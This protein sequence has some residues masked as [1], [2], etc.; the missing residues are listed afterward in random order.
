[1]T[2]KQPAWMP[3]NVDIRYRPWREF[4]AA[5]NDAGA[6]VAEGHASLFN[7]L[8]VDL[9]GFREQVAPGA[10]AETIERDDIVALFNHDSNIPLGRT[11]A[12]TLRL[13]E[14]ERGLFSSIDI[15]VSQPAIREAIVRGDV[16]SQSIAFM[17][18]G[19]EDEVWEVIDGTPI[20]TILRAR[21][22]D[23]SPVVFPAQ[24][25]TD[26]AKRSLER[27]VAAGRLNPRYD[28]L[29]YQ[30]ARLRQKNL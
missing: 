1:M 19:E 9:G 13:K 8:T 5:E 23:A 29:G 11:S 10:F 12:G 26:V 4:R 6:F 22:L 3:E 27:A 7:E 17:V 18:E 30:Q 21:L 14:D 20:R 15:P 28:W 25:K 24:P 16:E 2:W